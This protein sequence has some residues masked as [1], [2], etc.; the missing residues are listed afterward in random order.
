MLKTV[1]RN[2]DPSATVDDEELCKELHDLSRPESC[3]KFYLY[4]NALM[5]KY[6]RLRELK[7]M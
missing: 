4:S 2:F 5:D 6:Q 1:T 3:R 7:G